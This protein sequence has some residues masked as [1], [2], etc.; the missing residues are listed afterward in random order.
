[1]KGSKPAI[2][3]DFSFG[4]VIALVVALGVVVIVNATGAQGD[5]NSDQSVSPAVVAVNVES[6]R[7]STVAQTSGA[8][9]SVKAAAAQARQSERDSG[10]SAT[11]HP[12]L[13]QPN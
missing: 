8:V 5:L 10:S 9:Q 12:S 4:L 13:Q 1:M 2:K 3:F 6:L 11:N 7:G